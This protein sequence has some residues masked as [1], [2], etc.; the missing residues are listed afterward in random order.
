M[1]DVIPVLVMRSW[2]LALWFGMERIGLSEKVEF[3]EKY[4]S[5]PQI[6]PRRLPYRQPWFERDAVMMQNLAVKLLTIMQ[7]NHY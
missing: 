5:H 2:T 4:F 1:A 7:S 3:S 6:V